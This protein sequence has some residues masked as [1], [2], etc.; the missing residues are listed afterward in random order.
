MK[1]IKALVI[2]LIVPLILF[3]GCAGKSAPLEKDVL[4]TDK[5]SFRVTPEVETDHVEFIKIPGYSINTTT[6]LP[7]KIIISALGGA[8]V[9]QTLDKKE[10]GPGENMTITVWE[11]SSHIN[12]TITINSIK[13]VTE[14][15]STGVAANVTIRMIQ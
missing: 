14:E 15:G 9:F 6:G 8:P 13:F 3:S 11:R 4:L 7:E 1:N 10:L 5:E 12:K 2:L